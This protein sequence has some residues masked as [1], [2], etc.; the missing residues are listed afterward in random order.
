MPSVLQIFSPPENPVLSLEVQARMPQKE[1]VRMDSFVA[2]MRHFFDRFF[3]N[4]L[5]TGDGDNGVRVIQM[6]AFVTTPGLMFALTLVPSYLMFPPNLV[7][8]A[9]WPRVSDHY[10]YVMYASVVTGAAA[11]FEWDLLFPDLIDILVLT[12]LPILKRKLFTAKI[13]ALGLFLG[14]FLLASGSMGAAALPLLA[15]EPSFFRHLISHILSIASGGL[16]TAALFVS[17]QGIL[18]NLLGEKI[19]RWISPVLQALSLTVLLIVLFLFPLLAENLRLLLTSGNPSVQWF[20][21][22]WFL[23]IYQTLLEGRSAA[24][25]FHLLAA[26]G[27]LALLIVLALATLTYPLAY[28]RKVRSAIEGHVAKNSRNWIAAAKDAVLHAVFVLRPSQRAVYHFISQSLKRAPHH[29]VYLSMYGGVGLAF[30]IATTIG[31]R[32]HN[33][34][35]SIVYSE[36]G[37]RSAIPVVAFLVV[38]GLKVAFMSPVELQ[39]NWPFH[40]IGS[41]PNQ[42]HVV[43]TLRWTLPRAVFVTVFVLVFVKILSPSVFPGWPQMLTQLLVAQGLCLLLIDVLLLRFLSVPFTVPL[44]YSKRN[45]A[46]YIAAFLLLF[47]PFIQTAVDI[48]KWIEQSVWH[49]LT[50]ALVVLAAHILLQRWQ[51]S[52]VTVRASLPEDIDFDEFPQRLGLS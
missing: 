52:M 23:G 13:A 48:G 17:L 20:P 40:V 10:F 29:R 30:L 37:L 27:A 50:V 38:S 26:R 9:Y 1:L 49:F 45:L 25:I 5:T 35:V 32:Q 6:L 3:D 24:H 15:D 43:A 18:L 14:L 12:P 11:V 51:R 36:F 34:Q 42:D 19:F 8:R 47:A 4:P 39:A 46:F 33:G 7:P 22:F 28:R 41:R 31:F 16:F 2:L 21:P 44:A